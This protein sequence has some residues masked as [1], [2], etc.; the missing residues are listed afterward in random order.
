MM[1]KGKKKEN[2]DRRKFVVAGIHLCFSLVDYANK[3]W[4]A[5]SIEA[6]ETMLE[7]KY[8]ADSKINLINQNS[9]GTNNYRNKEQG[10]RK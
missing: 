4:K 10:S 1:E 3:N 2:L 5:T 9:K 6:T 8:M 7:K